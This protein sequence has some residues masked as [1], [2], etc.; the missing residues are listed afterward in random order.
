MS[1]RNDVFKTLSKTKNYRNKIYLNEKEINSFYNQKLEGI[2][3]LTNSNQIGGNIKGAINAIFAS[4]EVG[5]NKTKTST[6]EINFDSDIKGM[7]IE[8]YL[9]QNNKLIDLNNKDLD[10]ITLSQN[11]FLIYIGNG[12][13]YGIKEK[14]LVSI[15][16]RN[17]KKTDGNPVNP[18]KITFTDENFKLIQQIREDQEDPMK[19]EDD[20]LT[21]IVFT[22]TTPNF[23][24][25]S[26]AST[27]WVD[28]KGNYVS[29]RKVPPFGI[30]GKY[31]Q[32]EQDIL[33]IQP[34]WVW[35]ENQ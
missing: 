10:P 33:F 3:K 2:S 13:I 29:Y 16:T 5:G 9:S 34:F 35:K 15:N 22:A 25:A 28:L 21:T 14:D 27:Q 30:F 31:E 12:S 18:Q 6:Y 17:N 20:P 19:K 11:D 32:K 26:I 8:Y 4:L 1:D 23:K 7:L 24:L